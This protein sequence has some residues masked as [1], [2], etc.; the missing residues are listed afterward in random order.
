METK[1]YQELLGQIKIR[2]ESLIAGKEIEAPKEDI[3]AIIEKI[4]GLL[5]R[6]KNLNCSMAEVEST[7]EP[8]VQKIDN[9]NNKRE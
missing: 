7:I 2:L 1:N 5:L 8:I 3:E 6:Y 4:Q 9:W